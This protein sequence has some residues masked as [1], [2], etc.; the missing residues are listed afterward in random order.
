MSALV[1]TLK[2]QPPQRCD[3]SPLT[4]DR[5][6]AADDIPRIEI[7]TTRRRLCAGDIFGVS[8]DDASDIHFEGG[9]ER[10]DL[11]GA[12]MSHGR[13]AV[14]GDVGQ[15]LGRLMRGGI[16][17]VTGDAGRLAGSGMSGG[18]IDIDGDA[19]DLAGAPLPG[20]PSGMKGGI[21]RIK[22][23]SGG[24]PGDRMRR[25]L[26]VVEGSAGEAVASRMIGGT[27]ICFGEAGPRP[28]YLMKRGTIILGGGA[29]GI[30]PTFVDS[31]V[32]ELVAMRLIAR[33][34][35]DEGI[36]GGSLLAYTMRRL[37]GDT[38]VLGKGEILL[39]TGNIGI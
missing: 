38:A 30:T 29:A 4:P 11:I 35:I 27:I 37:V 17:T 25:G 20:E 7:Q 26:I 1:L 16:I 18:R 34:L 13:V 31:G 32:H 28:G 2:E 24:R 10:F 8:G 19:G 15:Q 3:L 14:T 39:P 36:E 21:L 6:A 9:S 5:L 22:G 12:G 33:W 23:R